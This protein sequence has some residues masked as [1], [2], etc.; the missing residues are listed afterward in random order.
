MEKVYRFLGVIKGPVYLL[1]DFGCTCEIIS[2]T[3]EEIQK[4]LADGETAD[5]FI[6][7]YFKEYKQE[8]EQKFCT[9]EIYTKEQ[10]DF[11][12]VMSKNL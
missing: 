1:G 4:E 9:V 7:N 10:M 12:K 6:E 5:D 8:W 11:I 3:E 2:F